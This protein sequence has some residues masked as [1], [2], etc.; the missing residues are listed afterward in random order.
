MKRTYFQPRI[1]SSLITLIRIA[2]SPKL[3]G[4]ACIS[5]AGTLGNPGP[6]ILW[7]CF[8]AP[9]LNGQ[10]QGAHFEHGLGRSLGEQDF[11]G[12]P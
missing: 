11:L 8:L 12:R 10:L 9:L 5:F 4:S 6:E 2:P 3:G 7:K 1:E